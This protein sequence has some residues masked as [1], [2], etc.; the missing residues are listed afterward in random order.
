[1]LIVH[2]SS[3]G[4]YYMSLFL[5]RFDIPVSL[6][7][8]FQRI[9]PVDNRFDLSG[10]NKAFEESEVFSIFTYSP[11]RPEDD[12]LIAPPRHPLP[13]NYL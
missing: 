2:L 4:H 1:M 13:S 6:G 5:T 12:P 7:N 8:L 9:A 3:K 11:Q 10:L